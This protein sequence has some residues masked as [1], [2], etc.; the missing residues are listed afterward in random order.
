MA[1]QDK[2]LNFHTTFGPELQYISKILEL[3]HES[4]IGNIEEISKKTG[5]PTGLSS[6]KVV[7]SIMYASYMGLVDYSVKKAVYEITTTELGKL[8]F[9]EDPHLMEPLTKLILNYNITDEKIGAPQWCYLFRKYEG[10]KEIKKEDLIRELEK[11]FEKPSINITPVL[12]T[13]KNAFEDLK[14][15]TESNGKV[16]FEKRPIL[17]ENIYVYGYTLLKDW[18]EVYPNQKEITI[19]N[20]LNNLK[21]GKPFGFEYDDILE[22]LELME[23]YNLVKLNKQLSPLTIIKLEESNEAKYNLY[24]MLI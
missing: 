16:I 23:E 22:A 20:V 15:I 3:G 12:G 8:I 17:I 18:E 1:I 2:N 11:F 4:Y 9:E 7:P 10:N 14:L 21:W 6:G 5:I 24:S 19:L 13:Y